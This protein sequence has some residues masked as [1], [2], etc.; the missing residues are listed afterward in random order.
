[1]AVSIFFCYAHE[2]EPLLN[3][4]K[5]HL[6]SLQRQGLVSVWHDRDISAGVE[7]QREIDEHLN[8]AQIIL[9]LVSPDF[10]ASDYCYSIEAR[11]AME[12]HEGGEAFVIPII[13]RP[14]LWQGAPFGQLQALPTNAHPIVSPV[15]YND[16]AAFL[17]VT[18]GIQEVVEKINT[19]QVTKSSDF[20]QADS[21]IA[22]PLPLDY[23]QP[24][25]HLY[26]KPWSRQRQGLL[27]LL[28]DQSKTMNESATWHGHQIT[29]AQ[30]ATLIINDLLLSVVENASLDPITGRRKNYCEIA[31][32]GYGDQ[33]M[34][35]LMSKTDLPVSISDLAEGPLGQHTVRQTKQDPLTR[36]SVVFEEMRPYWIRPFAQGSRTEMA[37]AFSVAFQV[38]QKWLNADPV[39][40]QSFPPIVINIT[41]GKHSSNSNPIPEAIKL[42][43]LHTD[44]GNVLLFNCY[45]ARSTT[46]YLSFPNDIGQ[47]QN[48]HALN[49]DQAGAQQLFEM[50]SL[51][52]STMVVRAYQVF[53]KTLLSGARGF[54]Y[55]ANGQ[56]LIKFLSWGTRQNTILQQNAKIWPTARE[57][58]TA[59]QN[60]YTTVYDRDLKYGKLL[61]DVFGPLHLNVEEGKNTCVYKIGDWVIKCFTNTPP[62]DIQERYQAIN[63]CLEQHASQLP[64]L[65][66]Q[67]WVEK[68]LRINEQDWPFIKAPYVPRYAQRDKSKRTV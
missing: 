9:L 17:D 52:P 41:G 56:D 57:Y 63:H 23:I 64:F 7:W 32:F 6:R 29:L 11:R 48:L 44:D 35:L 16:D 2:D 47:L 4:L 28:L 13:L 19:S 18:Q 46:Q 3:K 38:V 49:E 21:Q 15:W 22:A 30:M 5:T 24:D 40:H 51:V 59:L 65:V 45:V 37:L 55:G 1:M 25:L 26:S 39:R 54:L 50:S 10:I 61:Q 43:Q 53:G 62:S 31:I 20:G 34:P 8:M 14:T 66:P 33:V 27:I 68:A 12:R 58:D 36:Q 67:T 42:R 60:A